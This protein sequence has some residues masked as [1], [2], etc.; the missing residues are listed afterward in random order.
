MEI[1]Y[2]LILDFEIG[3]ARQVRANISPVEPSNEPLLQYRQ[4]SLLGFE[5][6]CQCIRIAEKNKMSYL[7]LVQIAN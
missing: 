1:Y 4:S 7:S 5:A 2:S 3:A 6:R